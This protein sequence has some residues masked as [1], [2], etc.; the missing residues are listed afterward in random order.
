MKVIAI[1]GWKGSGKDTAADHL[2]NVHGYKKLSFAE[3]LKQSVSIEY[4]IPLN[5]LN[6]QKLKE[7]PMENM[8]VTPKDEF[9][10]NMAKML[11]K[12]FRTAEGKMPSD[13][14]ID[15][16]G[17]FIGLLGSI[18]CQLYWTPRALLILEGCIKRSVNSDYW[19]DRLLDNIYTNALNR[20]DK[21]VISDIRYK[22]EVEHLKRSV[23]KNLL[24]VR[25]ERFATPPS[26][27]PSEI[28]LDDYP[29]DL[30]LM[31]KG[32]LEEFLHDV[33]KLAQ[34]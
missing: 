18:P 33:D 12:E 5:W 8:P 4:D 14:H 3:P 17:A 16:S 10:L 31:N 24:T 28:N 22:T 19:A 11:Y 25:V 32:T 20:Q 6:D 26:Y 23:G 29:F 27:D 30:V 7:S 2:V 9:S 34:E 13:C 21:F 15:A 1:S